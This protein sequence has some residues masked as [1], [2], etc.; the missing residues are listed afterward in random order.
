M[1]LFSPLRNFSTHTCLWVPQVSDIIAD[2]VFCLIIITIAGRFETC[3]Y[4]H[5][6]D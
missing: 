5:R 6:I 3:P 1:L 2:T 4:D